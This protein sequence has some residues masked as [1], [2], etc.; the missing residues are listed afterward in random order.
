MDDAD[1]ASGPVKGDTDLLA[2]SASDRV[3]TCAL[4]AGGAAVLLGVLPLVAD[5]LAGLPF[6]PFSD[7]VQWV[8]DLDEWWGWIVRPVAG[9]VIGGVAAAVVLDDE[10]RLEV[11]DDALVVLHGRDRRRIPREEVVGIHLDRRKVVIDGRGRRLLEERVEAPRAEI[12]RVLA[13]RG[14]PIE[15]E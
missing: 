8:G 3:W 15:S 9:L 10:W 1:D 12:L 5:A 4:L 11:A 2:S 14:Y 13:A 7:A 6:V